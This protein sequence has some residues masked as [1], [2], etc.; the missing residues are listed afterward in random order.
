[1]KL[2]TGNAI[3]SFYDSGLFLKK[4][5]F[6]SIPSITLGLSET[7]TSDSKFNL[8][9][10]GRLQMFGAGSLTAIQLLDAQGRLIESE[11]RR[12]LPSSM[13]I[14]ELPNGVYFLNALH[15]G[16]S[17]RTKLLKY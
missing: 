13:E 15:N 11:G 17:Y 4:Q 1:M 10:Q 2:T 16:A 9:S 7:A 12:T 6:R 3:D 8:S 5:S 14:A